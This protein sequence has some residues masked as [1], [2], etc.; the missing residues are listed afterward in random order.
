V[1]A[2]EWLGFS[3]GKPVPIQKPKLGAPSKEPRRKARPLTRSQKEVDPLVVVVSKERG[4]IRSRSPP[5]DSQEKPT[6]DEAGARTKTRKAWYL[7]MYA[8]AA[9]WL[10]ERCAFHTMAVQEGM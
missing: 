6:W 4:H 2:E 3:Q 1:A 8:F 9:L 10:G 5:K 7:C